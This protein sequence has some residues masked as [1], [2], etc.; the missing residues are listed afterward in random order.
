M[1]TLD[2]KEIRWVA[3]KMAAKLLVQG[4]DDNQRARLK[5][6]VRDWLPD[7]DEFE[8]RRVAD[9][10]ALAFRS[11]ASLVDDRLMR[12]VNKGEATPRERPTP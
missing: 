11:L 8:H 6:A 4:S 12:L 2:D 7:C 3:S 10:V 5:Q 1:P 9:A